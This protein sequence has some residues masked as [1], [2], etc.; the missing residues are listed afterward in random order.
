ME[1]G[2]CG[3]GDVL[4]PTQST[5]KILLVYIM[6]T[7]KDYN[8]I[9]WKYTKIVPTFSIYS[10]KIFSISQESVRSL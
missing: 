6:E 7:I 8:I 5:K 1:S 10:N 4:P 9:S 2:G 3:K